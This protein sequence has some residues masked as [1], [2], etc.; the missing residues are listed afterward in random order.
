MNGGG[1]SLRVGGF[2]GV[3]S[4]PTPSY[5]TASSYAPPTSAT[6]A[7]FG[8]GASGPMPSAFSIL[9]PNDA[10]GVSI[11]AGAIALGLLVFIRWSLPK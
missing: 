11:T 3:R 7:A 9:A 6:A 2:G 1:L 8:P 10:F 5:G 4:G